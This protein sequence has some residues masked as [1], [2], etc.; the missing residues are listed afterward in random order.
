MTKFLRYFVTIC[1]IYI[2]IYIYMGARECSMYICTNLLA[3][4]IHP[5]MQEVINEGDFI[6]THINRCLALHK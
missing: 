3:A 1:Y 6:D 4:I 5:Q 2:D